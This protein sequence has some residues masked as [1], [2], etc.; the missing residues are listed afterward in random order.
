MKRLPLV[1][2]FVCMIIMGGVGGTV[3]AS[4]VMQEDLSLFFEGFKGTFV[5]YDQNNDNYIIY[6]EEQ[7][8]KRVSPCS[9][10][11]IYN[12]LI[13]L[14]SGVLDKEDVYTLIKWNGKEYTISSWNRDHTLASAISNSVVWYYQEVASRV[15]SQRMQEYINKLHYGN[16]DISGGI[17]QFWLRSSIKIS[18]KEQVELLRKLYSYEL[19]FEKENIDIVKRIIV[20]SNENAVFSGKTGSGYENDKYIFGW[21]V[22]CIERDGNKYFF[23]TNIEGD[24]G[25]HGGKARE[26]TKA[27]LREK[28]LL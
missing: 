15:G 14:E 26:I 8:E 6:N 13:G 4:G 27:I 7:A 10:F 3:R 19:P 21:F 1:L 18:A 5:L 22:G 12:S 23:A 24:D 17:T 11:K 16:Q 9:T 28:G 25:A 2:F 20:L